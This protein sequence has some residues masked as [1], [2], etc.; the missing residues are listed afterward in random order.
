MDY[1]VLYVK[2]NENLRK[3]LELSPKSSSF[4]QSK[5]NPMHI[6]SKMESLIVESKMLYIKVEE[7]GYSCKKMIEKCDD[8][9]KD[10]GRYYSWLGSYYYQKANEQRDM[11]TFIS[12]SYLKKAEKC[13]NNYKRLTGGDPV[14]ERVRSL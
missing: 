12:K 10:V 14:R 1:K 8:L 11:N 3:A 9:L 5:K 6:L 4:S 7:N 13:F 2:A